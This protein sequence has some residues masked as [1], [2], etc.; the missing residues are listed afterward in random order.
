MNLLTPA[1][2]FLWLLNW[3]LL[4]LAA[5][6]L[7]D[8]VRRPAA[9]FPAAGKLTKPAWV[10]ITGVSVLL[11]LWGVQLLGLLGGLIAV[12]VLVYLLDVRPAVRELGRPG[13]W[14]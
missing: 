5:W 14:G 2:V 4:G 6:A 13:G 10:G 11:C 9:A 8:A 12:A 1:N 7:L 3:A